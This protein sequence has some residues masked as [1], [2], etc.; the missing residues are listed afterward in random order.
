[1]VIK[2]CKICGKEFD[3]RRS[4]KCCSLECSKINKREYDKDY[5]KNNCDEKC[6]YLK[7]Y[8]DNH[9]DEI[10]ERRKDYRENHRDEIN[11]YQKDYY[12][13][14]RDEILEKKKEYYDENRDEILKKEYTRR[15]NLISELCEQ[16]NG[17][18]E[19]I[20]ENIPNRWHEREAKMR[21]W[22]G[23]SYYDAIIAKIES[24]PVCEVTG[25][26]NN[27]EIHHLDSFN[28]FPEKGADLN[29]MIRI[30]HDIHNEFHG[31]YG[32]G[33]NTREQWNEFIRLFSN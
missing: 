27:L 10:L 19:Q 30:T 15:Q 5:Y 17:D 14:N 16:Y 7:Y 31:I 6:E 21:V 33:N 13:N 29:N 28:L 12:E 8:Y 18:L 32:Y 2:K 23:K 3:A 25:K 11:E 24:T 22:F 1:M 20:L 9:R 4:A 26:S